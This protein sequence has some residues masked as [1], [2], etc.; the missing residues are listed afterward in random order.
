[1]TR[2]EMEN[3]LCK[4][5]KEGSC[6]NDVAFNFAIMILAEHLYINPDSI[7]PSPLK[8]NPLLKTPLFTR[9]YHD[10]GGNQFN[11]GRNK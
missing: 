2:K 1:M 8:N 9:L 5:I 4:M 10:F 6:W 11:N 3:R 7:E